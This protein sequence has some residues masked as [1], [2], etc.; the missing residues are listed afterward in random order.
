MKK[1]G[2][3]P[4]IEQNRRP[5]YIA[6]A[7]AIGADVAA[8]RLKPGDRLPP[9]RQLAKSL[10][11]D[12]SAISRGYTEA[13]RR[14]YLEAHV[15][16]GT[17][18]RDPEGDRPAPDPRR[19]LEED[20]RMNMPPEPEAPELIDRMRQGFAHVSANIV[21]LLRYQNATGSTKDREIAESWM[22]SND[23]A[24]AAGAELAITPGAHA[25]LHATLAVLRRPGTVVL[26]ERVTYPG[27]RALTARMNIPLVGLD[28]DEHGIVPEALKTALRAHPE[29]I[30]YLNPTL[31]NPTTQTIPHARRIEIADVLRRV[32]ARLIE[33]DAYCFVATDAPAPISSLVPGLGWHIA[34]ISKIFGAGLRLAYVQVPDQSLLN[35]FVQAVRTTHVMTSPLS[36]ALLSRWMEDGTAAEVQAFVRSAARDRHHLAREVL[37]GISFCGH[38]DAFNI[39]LTVPEGQSRAEVLARWTDRQIGVIPS[40]VFTPSHPAEERLRVCLGGPIGLPDLR[41]ELGKLRE[42]L[43]QNDWAG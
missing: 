2:W 30:L 5:R 11:L 8:G 31:R 34:G 27:I 40:D 17:F 10:K 15:G 32:G 24:C 41:R 21:S 4:P 13:I 28:E 3:T 7:E 18:V 29:A 35:A 43:I 33:D 9:Q 6:I 20:P 37:T 42:A 1:P 39:W 16:R 23:I 26:C 19:A 22:Q 36:L 38:P 25:A 12:V 14:G